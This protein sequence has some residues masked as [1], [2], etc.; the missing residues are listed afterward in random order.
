MDIN[1]LIENYK[2]FFSDLLHRLKKTGINIKGMHLTH[3]LYRTT[4]IQEYKKLRDQLRIF[5]K[6]FVE[7]QFNGR[8]VSILILKKP[9][10]LEGGFTVSVI[11]LPAPRPIHMYPSGLESIGILVGKILPKFKKQYKDVLTGIKDHGPHCQPAFITFEN[12]KTVKFY[13]IHL[14]EIVILQ[15]WIFEE[16]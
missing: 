7:T 8:A 13:D 9:L 10:E 14:K 6:E 2:A 4:T 12:N 3:L 5:C 16:S 1:N 15:G 11:E